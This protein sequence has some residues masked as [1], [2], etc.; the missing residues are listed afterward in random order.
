[1]LAAGAGWR[2]RRGPM[3]SSVAQA[4]ATIEAAERQWDDIL[5]AITVNTPDDSFD[6]VVNQWLLYQTL[7]CRVWA[8]SGPYQL[9][10]AFGFLLTLS[11]FP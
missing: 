9:G 4:Q 6:L 11:G 3:S 2:G 7:A 5:G 1:M 10:G 8:R